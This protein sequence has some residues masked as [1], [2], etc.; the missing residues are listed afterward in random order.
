MVTYYYHHASVPRYLG[1]KSE[2]I[3]YE[4]R[5]SVYISV[6]SSKLVS[7]GLRLLIVVVSYSGI[8]T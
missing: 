8:N 6:D 5:G 1:K 7:P 3:L 4:V 2:N